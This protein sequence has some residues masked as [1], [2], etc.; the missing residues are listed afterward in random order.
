M[1][2]FHKFLSIKPTVSGMNL[3]DK[4]NFYKWREFVHSYRYP[5]SLDCS[6]RLN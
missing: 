6:S 1:D 5:H 2:V 4:V 3:F